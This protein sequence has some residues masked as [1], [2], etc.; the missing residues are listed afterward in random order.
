MDLGTFINNN[1][2][3]I[4]GILSFVFLAGIFYSKI[5]FNQREY[6]NLREQDYKDFEAQLKNQKE[7]HDD[8]I[9]DVMTRLVSVEVK[10]E[11]L[12]D[13]TFQVISSIQ[14]DI[15]EIMT[16]LKKQ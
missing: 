12:K 3:V 4:G 11:E 14:Q 7:V 5:N 9:T 13:K 15:R 2:Q 10:V 6:S 8:K 16:I 1:W